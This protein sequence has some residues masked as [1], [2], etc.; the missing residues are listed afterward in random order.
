LLWSI[1]RHINLNPFLSGEG[2]NQL[3]E[4]KFLSIV[5]F[6]AAMIMLA[7]T[8]N[9]AQDD[10]GFGFLSPLGMV[11]LTNLLLFT[12]FVL[13]A[14][15]IVR[16]GSSKYYNRIRLRDPK[17]GRGKA[18]NFGKVFRLFLRIVIVIAIIIA[19]FFLI[20][21]TIRL[22]PAAIVQIKGYLKSQDGN[23]TVITTKNITELSPNKNMT[24]VKGNL[25]AIP[26]K[27]TDAMSLFSWVIMNYGGYVILGFILL[28]ILVSVIGRKINC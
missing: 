10:A 6:M 22:A 14:A 25:S 1:E 24:E 17:I 21:Y 7:A 2:G 27:K 16:E 18:V 28:I 23:Q 15:I 26:E 8:V 11:V 3:V 20:Y 4:K 19:L 9:A 5:A 13:L 12:L